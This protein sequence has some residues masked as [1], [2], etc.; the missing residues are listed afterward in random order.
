MSPPGK[1]SLVV[2]YPCFAGDEVWNRDEDALVDDLI[3]YLDN[4]SLVKA[5]R[6]FANDVHRLQNAYPVYSKDYKET[7][8]IV[9]SYFKA[10]PKFMDSG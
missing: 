2:E 3:K 10:V 8:E 1:T 6:V 4:M 5:S 9:L 7:A